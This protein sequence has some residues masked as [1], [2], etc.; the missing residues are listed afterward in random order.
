MAK[1]DLVYILRHS[2]LNTTISLNKQKQTIEKIHEQLT[3][4]LKICDQCKYVGESCSE[5]FET[6]V[7][8]QVSQVRK[9]EQCDTL[10]H[11]KCMN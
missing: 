1:S 6:L 9:C 3:R 11:T 8:W 5:C 4:H 10:A 7:A 2:Y